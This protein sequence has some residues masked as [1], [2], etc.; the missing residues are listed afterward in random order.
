MHSRLHDGLDD[1]TKEK[2]VIICLK[3]E[4]ETSAT[5]LK[6]HCSQEA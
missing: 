4:K 1:K 2:P 3:K 5:N 6:I